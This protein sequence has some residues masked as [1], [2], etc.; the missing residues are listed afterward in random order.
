MKIYAIKIDYN[1]GRLH[2]CN[3][4]GADI[5]NYYVSKE[6]AL[7]AFKSIDPQYILDEL[8]CWMDEGNIC[9]YELSLD[10]DNNNLPIHT[11]T[12]K[13]TQGYAAIMNIYIVEIDVLEY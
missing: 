9:K 10:M 6:S 4:Q 13:G 1:N 8:T 5:L 3:S 11:Y 12:C 2:D 7:N